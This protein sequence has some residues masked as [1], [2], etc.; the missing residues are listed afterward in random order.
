MLIKYQSKLLVTILSI[1]DLN[2]FNNNK[3]LKSLLS[4]NFVK[5]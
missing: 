1:Y 3:Y 4:L 5:I 2:F